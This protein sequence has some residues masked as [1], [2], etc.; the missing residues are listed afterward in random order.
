MR[1]SRALSLSI[2]M[3]VGS[4]I[5]LTGCSGK[6]ENSPVIRKKFAEY[7][8]VAE[9]NTALSADVTRLNEEVARLTQENSELRAL[10]PSV[11]GQSVVTK[12]STLEAR[13]AKVEGV[14]GDR[15]LAAATTTTKAPEA[16]A[17]A[18]TTTT[19]SASPLLD[20]A[21]LAVAPAPKVEDGANV[22][23]AQRPLRPPS[24]K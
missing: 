7:D 8:K 15:V 10:L 2:L 24:R 17:A 18:A 11:D 16:G 4:V 14:A 21:P 13:L 1:L 9:A 19:D 6:P 3:T 5:A 20:A 22:V 12:L 23:A